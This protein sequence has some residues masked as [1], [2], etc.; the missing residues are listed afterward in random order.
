MTRVYRNLGS[1]VRSVRFNCL[2]QDLFRRIE[3]LT[4]NLPEGVQIGVTPNKEILF[5]NRGEI[6][7]LGIFKSWESVWLFLKGFEL[8]MIRRSE[9][10]HQGEETQDTPGTCGRLKPL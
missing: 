7:H 5:D 6:T 10:S 8:G 2:W 1:G 4:D 3:R 9:L